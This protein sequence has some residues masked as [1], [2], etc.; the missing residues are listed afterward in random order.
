MTAL[1]SIAEPRVRFVGPLDQF[2]WD[3]KMVAHLFGFDYCWEVYKPE[4]LR[5]WGYYVLPVLF[6]DRVVA[7]V[8][9]WCRNGV[10]E[11]KSWH[12]EPGEPSSPLFWD[13][14]D[15]ALI[16]FMAYCGAKSVK[17]ERTVDKA[18]KEAAKRAGRAA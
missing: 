11:F 17:C 8:D 10:L 5:T 1:D 2:M 4:P 3:R 9:P 15:E 6:G 13:A 18:V 12:W 16:R 7:R 14:F